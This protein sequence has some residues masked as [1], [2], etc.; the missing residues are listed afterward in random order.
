MTEPT[1]EEAINEFQRRCVSYGRHQRQGADSG[2]MEE[3]KANL[4]AAVRAAEQPKKPYASW[5]EHCELHCEAAHNPPCYCSCDDCGYPTCKKAEQPQVGH[6]RCFWCHTAENCRAHHMQYLHPD[7]PHPY[8]HDGCKPGLLHDA[9][10]RWEERREAWM[11]A[12][13][14]DVASLLNLQTRERKARAEVER[15][16]NERDS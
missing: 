10:V 7:H 3:G 12:Q 15:L 6:V 5:N 1:V 8:R 4:I 11:I 13:P 2:H 16:R 14:R 9:E